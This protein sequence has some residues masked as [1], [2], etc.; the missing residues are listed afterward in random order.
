MIALTDNI[1]ACLNIRRKVFI[2]EQGVAVS[3]EIDELDFP[4]SP[5]E[6]FLVTNEAGE[7]VGTFRVRTEEQPEHFGI[8]GTAVRLQR[9]CFLKEARGQGFGRETILFAEQYYREKG[10]DAICL[11]AQLSASGFYE[12]QGFRYT[13]GIF[14]EAG[15]LHR[16]M[17]KRLR[18]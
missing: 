11:D 4:G 3:E 13:S 7:P 5:A 15:I 12:K 9:F 17:A 16:S 6:H 8:E 1:E 18:G 2:E 10:F 14:E